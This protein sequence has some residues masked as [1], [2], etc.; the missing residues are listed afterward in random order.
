LRHYAGQ[1]AV[2]LLE[3]DDTVGALLMERVSPGTMLADLAL[4]DDAAATDIA[5]A[6][7]ARLWQPPP[8]DHPFLTVADWGQA[9]VRYRAQ[10]GNSGPVDAAVIDR[11]DAL[12]HHLA[13][14][15]TDLVVLHGDLHH[16]NILSAGDGW[17]A[18][19]PKGIVGEPAYEIGALLRNPGPLIARHPDLA[20][21]TRARVDRICARLSLDRQRVLA[22]SDAQLVLSVVWLIEDHGP[23]SGWEPS[24]AFAGLMSTL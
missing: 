7:M 2:R 9:F 1:G 24:I 8:P 18:I 10:W 19:D 17:Q 16:D 3:E 11:A 21:L 6:V 12:F 15:Q 22:W 20:A 14:T 23:D 4:H 5:A 13:D